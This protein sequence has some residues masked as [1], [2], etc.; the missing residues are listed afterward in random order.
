MA[1]W[2]DSA[3]WLTE[4]VSFA[5]D[6]DLDRLQK[7]ESRAKKH[8]S[9][10]DEP[11]KVHQWLSE[12]EEFHRSQLK[13]ANRLALLRIKQFIEEL[14]EKRLQ[15]KLNVSAGCGTPR[16]GMTR[17]RQGDTNYGNCLDRSHCHSVAASYLVWAS[18]CET[19]CARRR[20][21]EVIY[22]F[23]TKLLSLCVSGK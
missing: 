20:P 2:Q 11:L 3:K 18:L 16:A 21:A 9:K 14:A 13:P 1:R 5:P 19:A 12:F 4:A 10:T 15:Y 22:S 17:S 8:F 23:W 7:L 6:N